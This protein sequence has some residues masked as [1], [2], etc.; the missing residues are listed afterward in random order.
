M[1]YSVCSQSTTPSH[2]N[3]YAFSLLRVV[4]GFVLICPLALTSQVMAPG[5]SGSMP[6][7]Y[8]GSDANLLSVPLNFE[9]NQ[10]QTDDTVTF[11]ARG[12]GYA[13]F[14][15]PQGAAF[16]LRTGQAAEQNPSVLSM[17]F[18]GA[19]RAAEISGADKLSSTVNYFIGNDPKRWHAG[20]ATYGKV[21]Y[22]EIYPGVDAVFYGNQ[23]QLEYDFTVAPGADP[24]RIAMAFSGTRPQLDHDGNVVL[25]LSGDSVMLR[26]PVLYQGEGSNRKTIDGS[27][28]VAGDRVRLQIGDY[29]HSQTLVID[30]V[31]SYLTYLG[32][33]TGI[34]GNVAVTSISCRPNA[35]PPGYSWQRGQGIAVDSSGYV[36]VTG[37]TWAVDF[38]TQV[39]YDAANNSPRWTAYVTKLNPTGTGL[40]YST[41]LGG[42]GNDEADAIAIDVGGNAYIVGQ[43]FSGNF[44]TT[45]DSYISTCPI[46]GGTVTYCETNGASFLTKL[47]SD[48]QSL[49]YSTY[50]TTL[51][52]AGTIR[53]VAVDTQGRAYVSGD[54]VTYGNSNSNNPPST[55]F[56]TTANA[57]LSSS[58]VDQALYPGVGNPGMA[59][60][61]V[62]S[63]DGSSLVYSTLFGDSNPWAHGNYGNQTQNT[64]RASGV[65]VDAAGNFYL[66]GPTA[67]PNIP[68]TANAFQT[69]YIAC[70]TCWR[71]YVAKFSPIDSTSG[72]QLI[73][74]TYLGAMNADLNAS[75]QIAG[76]TA[77]ADG[78]AYVTGYTQNPGFPTT[79]GT[80]NPGPCGLLAAGGI[81][82]NG[83]FLTKFKPDGG[84]A[85]STL[86]S[87]SYS[88]S[89]GSPGIYAILSP[90]LDARGNV[91]VEVQ[92][93]LGYPELNP[94]Q[95]FTDGN[96]KVG[97]TKFDPTGSKI[98]FSTLLGGT[99]G[100][101][102]YGGSAQF[103]GGLD[104]DPQGNIYV[105]GMTDG[106]DLPATSGAF[107]T[108]FPLT[109]QNY[110]GFLAKIY[111][112][113]NA[114]AALMVVPTTINVGQ[115]VTFTATVNTNQN[116]TATGTVNFLNGT[117]L[118]GTSTLD[119]NNTAMYSTSDL[120]AGIYSVTAAYL[121]DNTF[122]PST[123]SA[124]SVTVIG[125]SSQTI[126]FGALPNVT[127]GVSPIALT[128]TA[129]SGL[130][131]SYVVTGP[132]TISGSTLTIIGAGTVNVTA[133]QSGDAT[134]APATPLSQSF[135]VNPATLTVTA[136]STSRPFGAANPAFTYTITGFV[137]GDSSSV[138]SGT[139]T[140]TTTATTASTAGN[141]PIIFDTK[142]LMALNY[143][144]NYVNGT[145][146]VSGGVSQT[147]TFIA[148]SN[149]T[150]GASPITLSATA[151]SG[152][153]VSFTVSGPATVSGSTLTITGAGSVTVTANQAGNA[154]YA[155]ATSVSRSFT[156]NA[157]VL[158][159]TANN[160]SRPFGVANPA[161]TYTITGF[162]NGDSSSVVSGTATET[163]TA[164][165][166]SAAG[167]YPISFATQSL[168]AANYRFLYVSGT[169]TISGGVSQTIIF[170]ALPNVTYGV[171]PI[172][173][174]AT[175]SSGLPVS[176]TVTGPA[177]LSG[178]TLTI[179][180]TG[181]VTVTAS[182][183]GNSN[184]APATP[185][186]QSFTV[187][188]ASTAN[189]TITPVPP[190]IIYRDQLGIFV[191][192]LKSANGFK[193][194][195]KLSCSGGPTGSK[196]VDF[197]QTVNLNGSAY[198]V[199]GILF[200]KS[201]AP[202][203]YTI[204]ITGV[205][206]SLTNTATENFTVK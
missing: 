137:N 121:G 108:T 27:Y 26:K 63:A 39:P 161:F 3:T 119:A 168:V 22:R 89:K 66:A 165:T 185:V 82:Q 53:A 100:L 41:Y 142:N 76:I 127:Y 138:V 183:A 206:G 44:P 96:P 93:N 15:T 2:R 156:V 74:S 150:Y 104:V 56:P 99:T 7:S 162:V 166:A 13:L 203:T 85:W 51:A 55:F 145:L 135:T 29:D 58:L 188:S 75:D 122:A 45:H 28:V 147:I 33:S 151:S 174:T 97:I 128:A 102:Q 46:Q 31:I 62:F 71:S 205:S 87:Y 37:Q 68:V 180:G 141:Y 61:T 120:P 171:S 23:R 186:S 134:Y 84:L 40:V 25:S 190:P 65:A 189:F 49:V 179:T 204:T 5:E 11:L 139:A 152:L 36:Y 146:T 154:N 14:L 182:Q 72:P 164:T 30:P 57:L 196:C 70:T 115:T 9:L 34:N 19:N 201:V 8:A 176:Y 59:F 187:S 163:T 158:T 167:T 78:G 193:G 1:R 10:G 170:N 126:A 107:R 73:Y 105:G 17:E 148:L 194:N 32:G 116:G 131:V 18:V 92:S 21:L 91:Y 155:A 16:K 118:L 140:E 114:A 192:Q 130:P 136:N 175:A 106:G 95:T 124:Q 177:T 80:Y 112:F 123:S 47:S 20:I 81:C 197:P 149:V 133:S 54:N 198:A 172:T 129:S 6:S 109:S 159:V 86:V 157:A 48:G 195:V 24:G 184:Y 60:L 79:T 67:D 94:V 132:A 199:T 101:T 191:L 178:S 64:T 113:V 35:C 153:P 98:F 88:G 110:T 181:T 50:L 111:P 202:G 12:D 160:A 38:P 143:N 43:T 77:D 52:N 144:F 42:S 4:L 200:P 125:Q 83:A 173:L 69:T 90:R 117:T 169:L 103:P